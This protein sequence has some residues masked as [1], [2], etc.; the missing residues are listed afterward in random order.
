MRPVSG[1]QARI[2]RYARRSGILTGALLLC[3]LAALVL[4]RFRLSSLVV[5]VSAA[6]TA[7]TARAEFA[8]PKRKTA[9][10]SRAVRNI[11]N[12]LSWCALS[13]PAHTAS[14]VPC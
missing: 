7:T 13:S 9:R 6:T 14:Y 11:K 8:V 12:L 1:D 5:L 4:A 10:Y 3:T 2:P